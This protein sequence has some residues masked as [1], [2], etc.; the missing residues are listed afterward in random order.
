M[1]GWMLAII[2]LFF[3]MVF[4][5][6]FHLSVLLA[7]SALAFVLT[8]VTF[9]FAFIE[10]DRREIRDYLRSSSSGEPWTD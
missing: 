5:S 3:A 8:L 10:R 7:I 4:T 1:F 9:L 2:F 6:A